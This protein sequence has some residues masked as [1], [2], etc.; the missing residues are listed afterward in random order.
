MVSLPCMTYQGMEHFYSNNLRLADHMLLPLLL[1]L[2]QS[3]MQ[4]NV[5]QY[6]AMSM[7]FAVFCLSSVYFETKPINWHVFVKQNKYNC[8]T[9]IVYF[10]SAFWQVQCCCQFT[11]SWS[12]NIIFSA[13]FLFKLSQLLSCKRCSVSSYRRCILASNWS[14]LINNICLIA[15]FKSENLLLNCKCF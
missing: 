12:W 1:L 11:S 10:N 6:M 3:Y 14:L 7:P 15:C 4:Q 5:D 2:Q 13:K 9:Q 8:M